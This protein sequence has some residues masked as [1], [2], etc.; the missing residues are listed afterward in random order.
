MEVLAGQAP[1]PRALVPR[2]RDP[3]VDSAGRRDGLQGGP[4]SQ[5]GLEGY[6]SGEG[7]RTRARSRR[8]GPAS[9]WWG[10]KIE[11]A[12]DAIPGNA[13]PRRRTKG[14]DRY[15]ST[16]TARSAHRRLNTEAAK[17]DA[18]GVT[19][20][21][22][23]QAM[24]MGRAEPRRNSSA[25][26]TASARWTWARDADVVILEQPPRSARSRSLSRLTST[27]RCTTTDAVDLGA[28]LPR[29]VQQRAAVSRA[30]TDVRA[31]GVRACGDRQPVQHHARKPAR[32]STAP[33]AARRAI[34]SA[35]I[36]PGLGPRDSAGQLVVIKGQHHPGG[37][38]AI[39]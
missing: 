32:F 29:A 24:A 2:R 28:R 6:K 17:S 10:Y 39:C 34:T 16:P 18:A 26:T 8:L 30:A 14:A 3:R 22:D 15:R 20:V 21:G 19:R 13:R 23:D 31:V 4:R 11:A 38:D 12:R 9:D 27:A 37:G 1:G 36:Y 33:A 5:R 25:S 7:D 35:R